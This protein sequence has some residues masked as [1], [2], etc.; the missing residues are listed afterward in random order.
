MVKLLPVIVLE[1]LMVLKILGPV[2]TQ[3]VRWFALDQAVDEVSRLGAP[4]SRDLLPFNLNLLGK[5]VV[6]D[7]LSVFPDIW[8]LA[9]HAF[10]C[11]HSHSKIV[12]SNTVVLS[13]HD[14]RSHVAGCA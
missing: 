7:L 14:L 9:E 2:Q 3:S 10:V 13:A 12:H 8:S 1:P 11:D 6:S 4:A 5:Y